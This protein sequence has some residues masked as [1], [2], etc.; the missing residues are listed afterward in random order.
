MGQQ[1]TISLALKIVRE[2]GWESNKRL[3]GIRI[4]MAAVASGRTDH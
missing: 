4:R 3:M 2:F 1:Q